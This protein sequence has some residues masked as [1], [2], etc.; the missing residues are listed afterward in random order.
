MCVVRGGEKGNFKKK[1]TAKW[2]EFG[3]RE[4]ASL[5]GMKNLGRDT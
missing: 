2:Q 1:P 4:V 3:D 5:L